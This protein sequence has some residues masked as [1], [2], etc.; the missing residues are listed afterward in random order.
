LGRFSVL[1]TTV[2]TPARLPTDLVADEKH[3]WLDGEQ[4]YLATT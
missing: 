1:G 3:S 4:I 2:K